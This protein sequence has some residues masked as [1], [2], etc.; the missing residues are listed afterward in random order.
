MA[1]P[2]DRN[3]KKVCIIDKDSIMKYENAKQFE[4]IEE[5][6][7]CQQHSKDLVHR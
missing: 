7:F 4:K 2:L 6:L 3:D 5:I 1:H